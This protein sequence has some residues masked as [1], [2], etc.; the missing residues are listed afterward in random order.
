MVLDSRSRTDS[1]ESINGNGNNP[2]RNGNHDTVEPI[3]L[4]SSLPVAPVNKKKSIGR[5]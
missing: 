4:S 1:S 3:N 5:W 2:S